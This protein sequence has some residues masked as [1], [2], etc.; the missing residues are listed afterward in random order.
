M[1]HLTGM[2]DEMASEIRRRIQNYKKRYPELTSADIAKQVGLSPAT[3]HRIENLH[4]DRPNIE[5]VIKIL[6]KIAPRDEL[7]SFMKRNYPEF[8]R[9]IK[10][11]LFHEFE[12]MEKDGVDV[13]K[14]MSD[15]E[16]GKVLRYVQSRNKRVSKT[17]IEKYFGLYGLKCAERLEKL[18]YVRYENGTYSV[19]GKMYFTECADLKKIVVKEI[20]ESF[21]AQAAE[22][23]DSIS[24]ITYQTSGVDAS[25]ALPKIVTEYEKFTS[26]VQSIFNSNEYKGED[27]VWVAGAVDTMIKN[28]LRSQGLAKAKFE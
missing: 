14:M 8:F 23:K 3:F 6:Q 17:E 1:K 15:S 19:L 12:G 22:S 24:Y 20:E 9:A 2:S 7:V 27:S 26:K 5:H 18:G 13:L 10:D 25:K 11:E 21:H 28:S 4:R 16:N